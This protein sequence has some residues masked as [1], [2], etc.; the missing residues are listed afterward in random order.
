MSELLT[1]VIVGTLGYLISYIIKLPT[2]SLL[3]PMAAVILSSFI[4]VEIGSFDSRI[5]FTL[6]SILGVYI[7]SSINRD[8]FRHMKKLSKPTLLMV[9]WTFS[10]TFGLGTL[11]IIYKDV[12]PITAF[13]STSPAGVSE[14]S[15]LAVSVGADI[16]IVS[17]FQLSRMILTLLVFIPLVMR[18]YGGNSEK[19]GYLEGIVKRTGVVKNLFAK[20]KNSKNRDEI[21]SCKFIIP[22]ALGFVGSYIAN[23]L[24]VPG[25]PL[26]GAILIIAVVSLSGV[27]LPIVPKIFKKIIMIGVGISVGSS[28]VR[29]ET[30]KIGDHIFFLV[31][32]V[33]VIFSTAYLLSR[34]IKKI[35]GW[36]EL[37]CI[38]ATAPAGITPIT[39]IAYSNDCKALEVSMLHLTRLL[40][41]KIVIWPII[42]FLV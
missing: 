9:I 6:Q 11:L 16:T 17:M 5:L 31:L 35:T 36:D 18:K 26:I 28:I 21:K 1:L 34:I 23:K 8:N 24:S 38:L 40:T 27:N 42:L 29:N 41:V 20:N 37:T 32:F 39:I 3:G 14:M 13:L 2:A 22:I 4:G 25:G 33:V 30:V 12:E 7:G 19:V 15:M 10:L